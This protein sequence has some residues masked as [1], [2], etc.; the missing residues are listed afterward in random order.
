[1]YLLMLPFLKISDPPTRFDAVM[2][3]L[4]NSLGL[5]LHLSVR[6]MLAL[7]PLK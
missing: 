1:M 4:N 2:M 6:A 7:A 3:N 5:M